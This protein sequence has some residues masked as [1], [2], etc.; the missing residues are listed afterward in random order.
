MSFDAIIKMG[1]QKVIENYQIVR[2]RPLEIVQGFIGTGWSLNTAEGRGRCWDNEGREFFGKQEEMLEQIAVW[3]KDR[4]C[5]GTGIVWPETGDGGNLFV[6]QRDQRLTLGDPT[7]GSRWRFLPGFN[8]FVDY[9]WYV[10]KLISAVEETGAG[11]YEVEAW[12]HA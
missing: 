12:Y 10:P 2:V 5:I 6:Y 1:F 8:A 3:Q 11:V 7:T 9:N 4:D